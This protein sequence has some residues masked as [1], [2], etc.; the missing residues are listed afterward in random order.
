M[1]YSHHESDSNNRGVADPSWQYSSLLLS[2]LHYI[3]NKQENLQYY[4]AT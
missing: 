2:E 1:T 3:I 4:P